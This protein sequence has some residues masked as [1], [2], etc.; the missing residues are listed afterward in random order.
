MSKKTWF[1]QKV[2][3]QRKTNTFFSQFEG[4]RGEKTKY[5]APN[6]TLPDKMG[7]K[8]V[9]TTAN[10]IKVVTKLTI[11]V[12]SALGSSNVLGEPEKIIAANY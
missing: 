11:A 3:K 1:P 8:I 6:T 7:S 2:Y 10:S 9:D 5:F 4:T 12:I